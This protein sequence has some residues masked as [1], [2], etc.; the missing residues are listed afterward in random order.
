[1]N[2]E[3]FS[4]VNNTLFGAELAVTKE[5]IATKTRDVSVSDSLDSAHLPLGIYN[6]LLS[7]HPHTL[8]KNK[9]HKMIPYH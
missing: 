4:N 9:N 6:T 3:F 5:F 8:K 2:L 7:N 1:M